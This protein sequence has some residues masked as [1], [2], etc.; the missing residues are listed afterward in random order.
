M[1]QSILKG[2]TVSALA[3]MMLALNGC[4]FSPSINVLGSYFPAWIICCAVGIGVTAFA[5]YLFA[6]WKI[7]EQLWPLALLYPC[8]IIFVS[9]S[10][11]LVLFR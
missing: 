2:L 7:I 10:L 9:C 4:S 6:R 5:H 8:L 3:V 11:W 1:S